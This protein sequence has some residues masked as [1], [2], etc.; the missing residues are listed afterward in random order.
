MTY[1]AN[2]L[3]RIQPSSTFA[4]TQRAQDLIAQGRDVITL[5]TGEPDFDT[6]DNVRIAA[7]RAIASGKTRYTPPSGIPELRDA[8]ARK[9][10]RENGLAY[11]R[12]ET[13]VCTGGKHVIANALL[14]TINEGDEVIIPAPYWVSYPELVALCNGKPVIVQTR[15]QDGLKLTPDV[16]AKHITPRTKWLILN[17]PSNPS[18][19][20]YTQDE[21]K[22]LAEVVLAHR[23]VLVM[24]DDIYEHLVYDGFEYRTIAQVEPRMKERT[25]TV[26]GVSKGYAMTGWRI[27]YGAGPIELM[28]AMETVQG[29]VTSGSNSVAQWAAVEALNGPQD[30]IV[31]RREEFRRRRDMVVEQL[32]TC[33]GLHCLRPEGAFYVFPSCSGAFAK[34]TLTGVEIKDDEAF[35][36]ELLNA[37]GVALVHGTA[38]GSPG[39]FRLSYA[40]SLQQ[41]TEACARIKRFCTSLK[42]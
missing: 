20:A 9:F 26:N 35:V 16:L 7:I 22:A 12:E 28:R 32:N 2:S 23:H 31:P 37:E 29:Q 6:P 15:V 39:H 33:P 42:D 3:A 14:A 11:R 27:G 30:H 5:S 25:L 1:L 41:L 17:S 38:F 8:I 24:S 34:K 18:G 19:A 13:I 36:V 21:L 40:S 10:A 4:A